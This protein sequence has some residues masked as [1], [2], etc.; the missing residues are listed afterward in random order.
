[1][2][3]HCKVCGEVFEVKGGEKP[4]CPV[5]KAEGD[6]LEIVKEEAAASSGNPY[7]GT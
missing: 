4:V 7:A 6:D 3:Y 1:M 2:K 5:C